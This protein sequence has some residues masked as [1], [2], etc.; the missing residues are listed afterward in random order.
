MKMIDD[1]QEKRLSALLHVIHKDPGSWEGWYCLSV[2]IPLVGQMS[3]RQALN[4]Q[5]QSY[6]E[7]AF[8]D[9]QGIAIFHEHSLCLFCNH[10]Q[11]FVLERV[12]SALKEIT[13]R[14]TRFSAHSELFEISEDSEALLRHLGSTV[15]ISISDCETA[16]LACL[17]PDAFAA[18][19]KTMRAFNRAK[20]SDIQSVLLV[21]DDPVTRWMVRAALKDQ[22]TLMTARTA[23]QAYRI[24]YAHHPDMVLLDINLPDGDGREVMHNILMRDAGA[25]IV[26]FSGQDSFDNMFETMHEGARGFIAKPF[27]RDKLVHHLT[28]CGRTES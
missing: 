10:I 14:E 16:A 17:F 20:K 26:M 9:Q 15:P 1:Q 7:A 6:L 5:L 19:D 28:Q 12:A 22:C 4:D 21:E 25:Y 18:Y 27:S 11:S 8:G 24:Y 13:A 23:A 3:K 2:E